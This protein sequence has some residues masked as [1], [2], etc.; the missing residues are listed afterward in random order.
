MDGAFGRHV[1]V[2]PHRLGLQL[3]MHRLGGHPRISQRSLEL[4]IGLALRLDQRMNLRDEFRMPRFGLVSA[5]S[6]ES[7]YATNP[8]AKLVQPRVDRLPSPA[9]NLLGSTWIPPT[10]LDCHF[11]LKLS[12]PK[13]RQ[14]AGR[15]L[16]QPAGKNLPRV[17]T[18]D[19]APFRK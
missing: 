19:E 16:R 18:D 2:L 1:P 15:R 10:M 3:L 8:G 11:G 14:L 9:E 7:V 4:R 5:S 6:R 17:G 13:P 12:S